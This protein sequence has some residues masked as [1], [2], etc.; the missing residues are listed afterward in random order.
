[1]GEHYEKETVGSNGKTGLARR[2]KQ[3]Q[4]PQRPGTGTAQNNRRQALGGRSERGV[5]QTQTTG[6]VAEVKAGTSWEECEAFPM[7]NLDQFWRV[8]GS[9]STVERKTYILR[10][11]HE[12]RLRGS[13]RKDIERDW[14]RRSAARRVLTGE[15]HPAE[16][17]SK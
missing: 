2:G 6:R 3:T 15:V 10:Q 1:M 7:Q 14:R 5:A 4:V 17:A 8:F 12:W 16:L 13:S 11:L 9:P